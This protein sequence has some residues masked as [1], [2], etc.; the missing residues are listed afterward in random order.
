MD[1]NRPQADPLS[2]SHA[3]ILR[4]HLRSLL[5]VRVGGLPI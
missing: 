3:H 2:V 4:P 1:W 5:W